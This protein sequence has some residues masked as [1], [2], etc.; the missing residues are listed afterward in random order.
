MEYRAL[1]ESDITRG[2][3]SNFTRR[4]TVTDCWRR[5]DGE[6]VVRSDPFVDD[7]SEEDYQ[8][9]IRDLRATIAANGF[10]MGVFLDGDLKGFAAV[11]PRLFGADGDYLDLAAIHVSEDMRGKGAGRALFILAKTWAK[12]HGAKKLYISAHSSVESQAFYR[13]MG[14]TEAREKDPEH[15][16][17]EPFDVQLE[18]SL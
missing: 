9:L 13:V 3:F 7:W 4:Q 2:L 10:V 11:A 1:A 15:V 5:V 17:R 8:K 6:W 16:R 14:C 12:G 18:C